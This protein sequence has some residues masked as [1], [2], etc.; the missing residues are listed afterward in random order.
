M[1]ITPE[2]G[3]S[4]FEA[5]LRAQH[6]AP[7]MMSKF[8]SFVPA[9]SRYQERLFLKGPRVTCRIIFST[10]AQFQT[11]AIIV[12]YGNSIIRR[13]I[14]SVRGNDCQICRFHAQPATS[15]VLF[16]HT[17]QRP[18]AAISLR[19]LSMSQ[20]LTEAPPEAMTNV[21]GKHGSLS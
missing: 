19:H 18:T 4:I 15:L 21:W 14:A 10:V 12:A 11:G 2:E 13:D 5:F 1:I 17:R 20:A 9:G 16:C 7:R 8:R 6:S 3:N